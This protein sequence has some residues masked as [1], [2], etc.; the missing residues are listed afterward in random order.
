[1]SESDLKVIDI[2]ANDAWLDVMNRRLQVI[3]A[4]MLEAYDLWMT[5]GVSAQFH[6][7][8]RPLLDPCSGNN[9]I[10]KEDQDW[11]TRLFYSRCQYFKYIFFC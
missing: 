5:N 9:L 4:E 10:S 8:A 2:L 11:N 6:Q 1:V 3:S 7:L